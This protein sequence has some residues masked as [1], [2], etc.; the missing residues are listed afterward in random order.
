MA[1]RIVLSQGLW[2]FFRMGPE[3]TLL[4]PRVTKTLGNMVW[5]GFFPQ[6]SNGLFLQLATLDLYF[7]ALTFSP[8]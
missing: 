2:V 1:G 5:E 8:G 7:R 3:G 4:V 6:G